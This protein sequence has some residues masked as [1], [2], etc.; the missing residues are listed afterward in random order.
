MSVN[1]VI[2]IAGPSAGA[3]SWMCLLY[4]PARLGTLSPSL[5]EDCGCSMCGASF[6]ECGYWSGKL[7][8]VAAIVL[9]S[10]LV[11]EC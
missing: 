4:V 9:Y 2:F 3:L 5:A 6:F 10:K 7:K 1:K 11:S 8:T